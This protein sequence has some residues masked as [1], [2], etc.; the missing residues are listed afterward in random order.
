M[1]EVYRLVRLDP[2]VHHGHSLLHLASSPET[3]TVGR[4]I[5]CHFPNVA[6]LN[7]LF[8]LGADP[9]CVDV[10]GQRPLMCV[11]SHRRLQTEE[12]A[13]LVALLI[14]NGAHLDATN[15]DGVSALDSQFRHVLVKS[16]LCI[17]DHITLACQAAR[18]ARRSGF[19]ARNASCFNLP[20]NLWSFIEMH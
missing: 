5:I 14:R 1:N 2:R 8:Q 7:L 18:V 20:D 3:S 6:V 10:D 13:S 15:K 19:N 11:L 16:G 4:F 17:L 12:Q 9:N